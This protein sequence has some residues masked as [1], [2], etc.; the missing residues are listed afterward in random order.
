LDD[1]SFGA[2]NRHAYFKLNSYYNASVDD[3]YRQQYLS[4]RSPYTTLEIP[5]Q[6]MGDWCVPLMTATIEDDGLRRAISDD[7][8]Y[9][10]GIVG[11]RFHLPKE[12]SNVLYTSLWDNFPNSIT[13]PV[14]KE[15]FDEASGTAGNESGFSYAYLL[16]AGS[17]NNMQSRI[18]NGLVIAN[19]EDGSADT[20]QLINPYNWCP[21]EQDYYFDDHA[22]WSTS[23]HPYRVHLGSGKVSRSLKQDLQNAGEDN[24]AVNVH[25]T[26]FEA[27]TPIAKGLSIPDGAAQLLKMPLDPNRKLV[28]FTLCT[29]S[30]DV[31]IGLMAITLEQ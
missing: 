15:H 13:I 3:I 5:S 31:V 12:G 2:S 28:G 6:G 4:P 14:T 25:V 11:L 8:Y 26:D 19:Y 7:N 18:A 17:T 21:I 9:D 24:G 23:Q 1:V 29:L 30:N 10:T 22:F 27:D 20:L 16:L